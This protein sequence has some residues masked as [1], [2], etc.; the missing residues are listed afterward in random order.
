MA[1]ALGSHDKDQEYVLGSE[2][3]LAFVIS[4]QFSARTAES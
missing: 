4:K 2:A 1:K 3:Y